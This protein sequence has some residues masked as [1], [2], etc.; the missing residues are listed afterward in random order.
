MKTQNKPMNNS[1]EWEKELEECKCT[2]RYCQHETSDEH[3]II[4]KSFISSILSLRQRELVEKI[5][6]EEKE[7]PTNSY[8]DVALAM[9]REQTLTPKEKE[10]I[11]N[12]DHGLYIRMIEYVNYNAGLQHAIE[13]IKGI[14]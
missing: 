1:Q 2:G 4:D 14:K 8:E 6:K 5:R 11:K 10:H 12:K 13:I 7:R 3:Y 9:R